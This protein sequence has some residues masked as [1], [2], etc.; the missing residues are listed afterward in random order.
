MFPHTLATRPSVKQL[1][2]KFVTMNSRIS[3]YD[4]GKSST[5]ISQWCS[6]WH[7]GWIM[8]SWGTCPVLCNVLHC[9]SGLFLSIQV[10]FHPSSELWWLKMSPD[11]ATSPLGRKYCT[12]WETLEFSISGLLIYYVKPPWVISVCSWFGESV[13]YA[14]V[15]Q[16]LVSKPGESRGSLLGIWR[17]RP[18]GSESASYPDL[19]GL[20]VNVSSLQHLFAMSCGWAAYPQNLS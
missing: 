18:P 17:V 7:W 12:C 13:T 20:S 16:S 9:I 1:K 4:L 3:R 15:A 10:I 6:H 11:I 14:F 19:Q 2:I 8:L 5:K